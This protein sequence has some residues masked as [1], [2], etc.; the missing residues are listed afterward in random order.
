MWSHGYNILD[1]KLSDRLIVSVRYWQQPTAQEWASQIRTCAN[2][3]SYVY[4]DSIQ[5]NAHVST[6]KNNDY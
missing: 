3:S 2:I 4:N 1:Y 6:D 5:K